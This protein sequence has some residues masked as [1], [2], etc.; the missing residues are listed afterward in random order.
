MFKKLLMT[1][2]AVILVTA[3][4]AAAGCK[5]SA[6]DNG[7]DESTVESVTEST[8]ESAAESADDSAPTSSGQPEEPDYGTL[9]L[10]DVTIA[11]GQE[12]LLYPAF[13]NEEY[14]DDVEYSFEGGNIAI[15][16][17]KVK[18]LV[19]DTTT[20]VTATTEHHQ[21][22]FTVTVTYL[23]AT[24][25]NPTGAESKFAFP[26]PDAASYVVTADIVAKE[27]RTYTRL[28]SLAY[29]GSNNS[30]YNIEMGGDG[31]INLFG[32]FN[33]VEKYWIFLFNKD[34]VTS[35]GN[36]EFNATIYKNGQA[37]RLYING[38]LVCF[39][40]EEEMAGYAELGALEV[41]ASAD[42]DGAGEY[43]IDLENI[44][45][46]TEGSDLYAAYADNYEYSDKTL[47]SEEGA[48]QWYRF[49]ELG[50]LVGD[51]YLFSTT[52][53]IDHYDEAYTRVSSFAFNSW[54]NSWYNIEMNG[55]GNF[56]L[57]GKFN[58]VEKYWIYL[59]NAEDE[60]IKVDGKITYTVDLLKKGMATWLFVNGNL[61]CGFSEAEMA[62]YTDYHGWTTLNTLEISLTTG[63]GWR[64]AAPY[65]ISFT[66]VAVNGADSE[67]YED[68]YS[69]TQVSYDEAVL[70]ND[71][72]AESKFVFGNLYNTH[73][74]FVL[75]TTV[76]VDL[77][78]ENGWT[79]TSAFAFN[80]SDNS[81]YNV[82]MGG[83]GNVILY[84]QFNG[85]QKYG[86]IL[87]NINDE[88]VLNDGKFSY[89]VALL[90]HGQA[91]WFFING[92]LV[93]EFSV[94]DL[95]GYPTLNSLEV[96]ACA[97]RDWANAGAYSVTIADTAIYGADSEKY[98]TDYVNYYHRT[99]IEY[100]DGLLYNADG[101][102]TKFLYGNIGSDLG[103]FVLETTVNV[104]IYREN[105]WTR[106]SA[107]A[108]NGSDNSWY[109]V[110]MGGDGNVVLYA[111]FNGVEKYG[112]ILFNINDEGVLNDG[113]FSYTVALM[114]I[115][116]ATWFFVNDSLVC[117][118][119]EAEMAG[120]AGLNPL[121]V[122]ACAN[123]DWAN[124][125]EYKVSLTDA[126]V[127]TEEADTYADYYAR[128]NS[129]N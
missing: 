62:G 129:A 7:G 54:D 75:E 119:S 34:E 96:T 112:I 123:R 92:V 97:N 57:F 106:T 53:V 67:E 12:T 33:G 24:L 113:K 81:W 95:N 22:T 17:G 69:A 104:E 93:C 42:R 11:F 38:K 15:E 111:H 76:N 3:L 121:E 63:A 87:F 21:A 122:T 20:T 114:K 66:N 117:S 58:G 84:A 74:D 46:G 94:A 35:D 51:D 116:Q 48:E 70:A 109:N 4:F 60:G 55:N 108:F 102:E 6:G 120:Y 41:T 27:F 78:R 50:A 30:W 1:V 99:Y 43:V 44:Y 103:N 29:N 40:T 13:S 101:A 61:V 56:H 83:D 52:V 26:T 36:I 39:F 64:E 98:T 73:G 9:T 19:P 32:H 79:R 80:G 49:G 47:A 65:A 85:V 25:T 115:G 71:T 16:D 100:A 82:E 28:C 37:T 10:N 68:R 2:L 89:T 105:G 72:G 45:Y 127:Y 118:F 5:K 31:N 126:V 128:V 90:K 86:I 88:G 91:T 8:E 125:G 107:F 77:Y 124:A 59:F 23:S 14:E 18:G 110:E